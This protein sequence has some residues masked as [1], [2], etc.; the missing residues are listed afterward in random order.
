MD[1]VLSE[2]DWGLIMLVSV[3]REL[4][5]LHNP[6]TGGMSTTY[7]LLD[8]FNFR[9]VQHPDNIVTSTH[10]CELVAR[11]AWLIPEQFQNFKVFTTVRHPV[12]RFISWW[13]YLNVHQLLINGVTTLQG[14]IDEYTILL[15]SCY[16]CQEYINPTDTPVVVGSNTYRIHQEKLL[17]ELQWF[18]HPTNPCLLPEANVLGYDFSLPILQELIDQGIS[19]YEISQIE[20]KSEW[21]YINLPEYRKLLNG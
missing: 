4:I 11:H 21:D 8:E 12:S 5:Y 9:H 17:E 18:L 20:E 10:G 3:E 2:L 13:R 16:I 6:K 14:F 1:Q 19:H 15:Q 7:L